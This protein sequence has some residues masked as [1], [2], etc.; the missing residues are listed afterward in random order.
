MSKYK[1]GQ[2]FRTKKPFTSTGIDEKRRYFICL[3]CS[4]IFDSPIFVYSC[5][6][7]TKINKYPKERCVFFDYSIPPFTQSCLIF[8]DTLFEDMTI[9][10]FES[11]EP[12]LVGQLDFNKLNEIKLKMQKSETISKK[13][14]KNIM[15]NFY[16]ENQEG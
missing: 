14:L 15:H 12:E 5:T 4:G 11:Y 2:V 9:S 16:L 6:T 13:V 1:V 3:G 7:T 8:L 10:E